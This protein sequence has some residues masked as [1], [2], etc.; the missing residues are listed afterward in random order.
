MA[1]SVGLTP[2]A[3]RYYER[4]GLL[5][6]PPRSQAGYRLYEDETIERLRFIRGA[7]RLGLKLSEIRELLDIR[8]RGLCPC[9]HADGM[10]RKRIDELDQEIG[11]LGDLRDELARML[12]ERPDGRGVSADGE[13]RCVGELF[14]ME[15]VKA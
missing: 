12:G 8:D 13:T 14:R 7:Q 9:G 5:S 4:I 10:L 6:C 3:V 15:G 2:D 1:S 11:R